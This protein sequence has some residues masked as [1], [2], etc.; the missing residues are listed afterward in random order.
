M[1]MVCAFV[2]AFVCARKHTH[3]VELLLGL[4]QH[5]DHLAQTAHGNREIRGLRNA[6]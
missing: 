6:I 1:C 2:C 5:V 3:C 4:E